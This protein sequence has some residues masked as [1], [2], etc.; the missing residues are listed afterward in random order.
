MGRFFRH[1]VFSSTDATLMQSAGMLQSTLVNR[2]N[3]Q[4]HLARHY[5][6]LIIINYTH[7]GVV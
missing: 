5:I 2:H 1:S 4:S 3:A 6:A 7:L